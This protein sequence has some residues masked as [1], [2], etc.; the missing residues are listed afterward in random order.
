LSGNNSIGC[1]VQLC[2]EK[3]GTRVNTRNIAF[4]V[5]P[6]LNNGKLLLNGF[7]QFPQQKTAILN[8]LG[9][10]PAIQKKKPA[11]LSRIKVLSK[12]KLRFFQVKFP[13]AR[14]RLEPRKNG[15]M[16]TQVLYGSFVLVYFSK[17]RYHYCSDP[18]GYLGYILKEEL[19]EKTRKQYLRWLNGQRGRILKT[20][21]VG[22]MLLPL[23]AEFE[24]PD[25]EHILL[26]SGKIIALGK[27]HLLSYNPSQNK[28]V[29]TI[30]KHAQA[31]LGTPYKWGGLSFRGIDC[32][33]FTQLVY[34]LLHIPL[35]R[36]TAQQIRFGRQ[37]GMLGDFS[38]VL[39][40]DLLFFMG[41]HGG[42]IHVGISLGQDRFIH[43][44][45]KE[46]I[47]ESCMDDPDMGGNKYR[48]WYILGRRILV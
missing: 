2:L 19:Q 24:C 41:G 9:K 12:K 1:Q 34:L 6:N 43:A 46:G 3:I 15:E 29:K 25:N 33:G 47:T 23:G 22:N 36:D 7:V 38:D 8:T 20:T 32:S 28:K 42:I 14:L 37:V 11:V 44:T 18:S 17:G 48:N 27:K 31:Y 21:R 45:I 10:I 30:L 35:P 16:G 4:Q 13:Y 40:G 39:P 5:T 26:P